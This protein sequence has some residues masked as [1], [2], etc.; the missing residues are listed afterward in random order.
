VG[1][2]WLASYPKSGNTWLRA[3]L[4]NY[5]NDGH[6]P[7]DINTLDGHWSAT[8]RHSFEEYTGL[9]SSALTPRQI[10]Y[11]RPSVYERMAH[12]NP[13]PLFFKVHDAY[14]RNSEG[15]PIFPSGVTSGVVY[16]VRNPL[17][18]AVSYAHHQAKGIDDIVLEMGRDDALLRGGSQLP[19]T[20]SS[21]SA[22]VRTWTAQTHLPTHIVRYEDMLS[23]PCATFASI[24]RF[25]GLNLDERRL[26]KAI[27]FSSFESLR[28]QETSCGFREKQPISPSFFREGKAGTWRY[29]LST[30]QVR[31]LVRDHREMMLQFEYLSSANEPVV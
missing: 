30:T 4:T 3:F 12:E 27:A 20:V 21:W 6:A 8:T 25:L 31:R 2:Y 13:D 10:N 5:R 15:L 9:E 14:I 26:D 16:L 19:Q 29:T 22:N 1:I 24:L 11:Y 7:A 28:N 23:R 17:D 18:V